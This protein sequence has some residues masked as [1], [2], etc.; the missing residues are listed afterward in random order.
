VAAK[1]LTFNVTEILNGA[2][3]TGTMAVCK[4]ALTNPVQQ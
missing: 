3:D 4:M 1:D 2:G